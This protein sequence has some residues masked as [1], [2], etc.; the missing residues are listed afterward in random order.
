[1]Y[2]KKIDVANDWGVFKEIYCAEKIRFFFL[3]DVLNEV[4][5]LFPSKYI[6]IGGDEAPK[7]GE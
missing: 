1:M 4:M 2:G 6:H 5:E 7:S 3:E